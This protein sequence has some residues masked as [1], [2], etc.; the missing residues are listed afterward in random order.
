MSSIASVSPNELRN[1]RQVLQSRRRLKSWQSIW[2]LLLISGM[3]GGLFW[4]LTLPQWLIQAGTQIEVEGNHLL[5]KDQIRSFLSISY[6][7][8]IWELPTQ[9]LIEQLEMT[10]PIADAR[11][12][13]QLLPPKLTLAIR[14]R[15]PVALAL[16]SKIAANQTKSQ[17]QAVG[18]LDEQ[19]VFIP[20]RFYTQV[21]KSFEFPKLK[22]IGFSEQQRP[23]WRELYHLIS[24]SPI[25]IF[26]VD[27]RDPSNLIL[28]TELGIVYCGTYP[29][30]FA[31]KLAVLARMQTL[32][33][34]IS[35][36]RIVYI[37][38]TN[39]ESPTIQVNPPK[40]KDPKKSP[41]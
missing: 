29:A 24:Q 26:E 4:G 9:R 10:P 5:S 6:P 21:D 1:R 7:Q 18:F 14:E 41:I 30:Q 27:W 34:R 19:G 23:Y 38:L 40:S 22:V 37:D 11:I 32:S 12:A 15:H 35:I 16:S 36:S 25:K 20:R 31:E 39:P 2:R 8:S 13:R 3:A 33:S 17:I 28:K